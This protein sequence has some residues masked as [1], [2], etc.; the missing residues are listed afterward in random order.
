[1]MSNPQRKL[2]A[3]V[4]WCAANGIEFIDLAL[5]APE[6]AVESTA[7]PEVKAALTANS[8]GVVCRAATYL[9]IENPSA[10]VRQAALNELRR[11]LDTAHT[12]GAAVCTMRFAGW[13]AHLSEA[14]GYEYYRQLFTILL[15]HGQERGVAVALEN[16][17]QNA[18]QLKHFRELFHRLPGLR[19]AYNIGHGNV[20]TAQSM[21][22]DYL[23]ALGDRLSHV[24]ISDNDGQHNAYLPFGAPSAGGIDLRRELRTLRSF[25]FD[26]AITLEMTGDRRWLVHCAQLLREQWPLAS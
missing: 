25:R 19:L 22:R 18:H 14:A 16:G 10:P 21:T 13:P 12:L 1:M 26:G 20:Q 8:I 11:A 5:E 3:E 24:R 4:E 17:P 15:K 7:W 6:A 9:P 23:F 2:G